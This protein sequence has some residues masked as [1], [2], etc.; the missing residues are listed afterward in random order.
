MH[1]YYTGGDAV[2]R[3]LSVRADGEAVTLRFG[4]FADNLPVYY[5]GE[6]ARIT[7]TFTGE[8]LTEMVWQPV[9]VN[10]QLTEQNAPLESWSRSVLGT[11]DVRLAYRADGERTTV[12]AEWVAHR[13]EEVE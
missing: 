3:L 13:A 1:I 9:L 4:L 12:G 11:S 7:M 2:P 6:C 10:K 8:V 5:D